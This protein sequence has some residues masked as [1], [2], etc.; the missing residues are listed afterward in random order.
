MKILQDLKELEKIGYEFQKI[1]RKRTLYRRRLIKYIR[2][3]IDNYPGNSH[4]FNKLKLMNK[5]KF[6]F[7]TEYNDH[8]LI[9]IVKK[10]V[11]P[12]IA[13]D[14]I[15]KIHIEGEQPIET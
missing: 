1:N 11:G 2:E 5:I 3:N 9:L 6:N 13:I 14:I 4:N 15:K 10:I 12:D 8:E 7:M